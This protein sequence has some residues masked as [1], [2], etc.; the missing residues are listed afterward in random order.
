MIVTS[1]T[2]EMEKEIVEDERDQSLSHCVSESGTPHK[3]VIKCSRCEMQLRKLALSKIGNS[4]S[5][6]NCDVGLKSLMRTIRKFLVAKVKEYTR[7]NQLQESSEDALQLTFDLRCQEF[8]QDVVVRSQGKKLVT[9]K[10]MQI[11]RIFL[12]LTNKEKFDYIAHS[13]NRMAFPEKVSSNFTKTLR[14]RGKKL[15]G[16]FIT[17]RLVHLYGLV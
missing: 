2:G 6:F 17:F 16:P 13:V 3:P 11:V 7:Q 4:L 5:S 15:K 8:F 14:R 10:V 12:D 1:V 9:K